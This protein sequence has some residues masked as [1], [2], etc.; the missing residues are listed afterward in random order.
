MNSNPKLSDLSEEDKDKAYKNIANYFN[1]DY[2]KVC[3]AEDSY[4][5]SSFHY[6]SSKEGGEYWINIVESLMKDT[7]VIKEKEPVDLFKEFHSIIKVINK[8][9]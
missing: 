6:T 2:A 8:S 7:Y 4:V 1:E 3:F 5:G 9:K